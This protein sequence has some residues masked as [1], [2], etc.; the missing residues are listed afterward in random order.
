M[1]Y[2]LFILLEVNIYADEEDFLSQNLLKIQLL[3]FNKKNF[4]NI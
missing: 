4:H 3:K 2:I 1:R